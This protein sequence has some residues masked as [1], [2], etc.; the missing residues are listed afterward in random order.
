VLNSGVLAD[1]CGFMTRI[2]IVDDDPGLLDVA[3]EILREENY[4]VE[5]MND[6]ISAKNL[7]RHSDF[8]LLII[9]WDLPGLSGIEICKAY[10]GWGG[11]SPII[12]LTGKTEI[13][14]KVLGLDSGAD[15]YLTK[16]FQLEELTARARAHLRRIE[17]RFKDGILSFSDLTIDP[18]GFYAKKGGSEL[19]LVPKEFAILELFLRNPTRVFNAETIINRVWGTNETAT[20]DAVRTHIKNLRKKLADDDFI[21]TVHSVGYRLKRPNASEP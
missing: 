8:D 13:A 15:D 20:P 19:K 16:P 4:D 5:C 7:L 17:G 6:G 21:E 12:M 3:S 14:D 10:R 18:K 9:D 11:E 2:L 1:W